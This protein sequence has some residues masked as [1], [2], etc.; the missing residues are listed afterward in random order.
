MGKGASME[1]I[2]SKAASGLISASHS[3]PLI[4]WK[5]SQIQKL[6]ALAKKKSEI[7]QPGKK[8]ITHL[9]K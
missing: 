4:L 3:D 1:P 7:P 2:R 8:K 5:S 9:H 6:A